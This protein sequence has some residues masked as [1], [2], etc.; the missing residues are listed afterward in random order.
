MPVAAQVAHLNADIYR[1]TY[2]CTALRSLITLDCNRSVCTVAA[3]TSFVS[4]IHTM[5]MSPPLRENLGASESNVIIVFGLFLYEIIWS[6]RYVVAV[7]LY[8]YH[9]V[10]PHA[11]VLLR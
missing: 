8:K 3:N 11:S 5:T 4:S 7:V 10:Q 6:S 1:S 2:I 9:R